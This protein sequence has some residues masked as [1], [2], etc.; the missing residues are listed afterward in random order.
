MIL[1][2]TISRVYYRISSA[3][4]TISSVYYTTGYAKSTKQPNK[5]TSSCISAKTLISSL[6]TYTHTYINKYV[7]TSTAMHLIKIK[8]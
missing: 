7:R 8:I 2:Y 1:F 6:N 3:Y 4:Y 5:I